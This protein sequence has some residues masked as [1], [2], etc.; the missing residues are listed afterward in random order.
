MENFGYRLQTVRQSRNLT[1]EQLSEL[2]GV[3][4]ESIKRFERRGLRPSLTIVKRLAGA[5]GVTVDE[6]ITVK[7]KAFKTS[8]RD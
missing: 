6:L 3:G 2:S 5:L 4:A 1:H 8:R 7:T